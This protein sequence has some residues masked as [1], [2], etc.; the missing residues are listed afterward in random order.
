M[1]RK[2][3]TEQVE[4][5]ETFLG[6]DPIRK[7]LLRLSAPAFTGMMVMATYNLADTIF[8]GQGVGPLGIAGL[9]I[10]FPIQMVVSS[11]AMALGVGGAS[12]V[13][14]ALGAKD[15]DKANN[16]A[17]NIL[18]SAFGVGLLIAILG[19]ILLVPVLKIFGATPEILP[20]ATDYM[21]LIF[22]GSPFLSLAMSGNNLMRAEG[23]A[24]M[25][26]YTM[27][28]ASLVNLSLDPIFIFALDMGIRGAA[29][30]TVI[31]HICAATFMF[32]YFFLKKS[33][34]KL[35]PRYFIP[36]WPIL[37]EIAAI[38]SSSFARGAS[39][40]IVA[41]LLNHLLGSYGGNLAIAAYGLLG[42]V[43]MFT[44]MPVIGIAQGFQPIAGFNFG[45]HKIK[46][47]REVLR[48]SIT[49]SSFFSFVSFAI[50]FLFPEIIFKVFTTDEELL[51]ITV[52]AVRMAILAFP[53]VGFQVIG[54]SLYQALGKAI[55]ALILA[56]SRQLLFF[57]PMLLVLPPVMGL[58]GIWYAFPAADVLSAG[59]T[60]FMLF[61]ELRELKAME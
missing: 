32:L 27:L 52:D 59:V 21:E 23:N 51:R 16:A 44:F 45:A 13:S 6:T 29:L 41:I 1:K 43:L 11:F 31:A 36:N 25:A 57:I 20:Y 18:G 38:G 9:T 56:L 35:V 42:R 58:S 26:M 22:L 47:V 14:R 5:K 46:R 19:S 24:K 54:A 4:K 8:V 49:I 39:G 61:R 3:L 2:F 17:A 40:S 15:P 37:G 50:L 60:G 53:L 55:P 7:L 12:V 10:A 30:A 33:A 48:L 34:L 28:I